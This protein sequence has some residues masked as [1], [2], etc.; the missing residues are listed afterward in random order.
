MIMERNNFIKLTNAVYKVLEY[1][2]E[3][4][5]LKNRA[6]E[7]ALLIMDNL[8]L[9]FGNNEWV[10]IKNC[11]PG[12]REKAALE[13]LENTDILLNYLELA[14]G[15]GWINGL[16]L[17]IIQNEY[18]KI[19]RELEPDVVN[20]GIA[21]K[22]EPAILQEVSPPLS[23]SEKGL[24]ERQRKILSFLEQK[25]KGQVSDLMSVLNNVTKRTIRRDIDELLKSGKV[26]RMGEFN[27]I[28]YTVNG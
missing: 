23:L 18:E 9:I 2:P 25:G 5:P 28:F 22:P 7:K 3:S 17:L 26:S 19:K 12:I 10:Q 11:L 1:L 24:S 16:S 6:K 4:D 21:E 20:G 27:Q 8:N 14:K 13:V 15:Q